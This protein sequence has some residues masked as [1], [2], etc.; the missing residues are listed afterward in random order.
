MKWN[1]LHRGQWTGRALCGE[2]TVGTK[3]QQDNKCLMSNRKEYLRSSSG[4]D[5]HGYMSANKPE[6]CDSA[7]ACSLWGRVGIFPEKG[8]A[9]LLP[10]DH[11]VLEGSQSQQQGVLHPGPLGSLVSFLLSH[12]MFI[13]SFLLGSAPQVPKIQAKLHRSQRCRLSSMGPRDA[14]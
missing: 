5:S 6:K 10:G 4:D 2:G 3:A 12:T 7:R 13:C 8:E 11:T 1:Q 9:S 14:G